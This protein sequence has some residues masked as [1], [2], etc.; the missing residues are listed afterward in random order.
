MMMSEPDDLQAGLMGG[1][2]ILVVAG[3]I[4]C[5]FLHARTMVTYEKLEAVEAVLVRIEASLDPQ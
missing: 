3:I 4:E 5:L 1:F 2:I